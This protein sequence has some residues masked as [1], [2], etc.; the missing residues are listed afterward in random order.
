MKY[1]KINTKVKDVSKDVATEM[2]RKRKKMENNLNV[3]IRE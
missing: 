1:I 3:H 2:I